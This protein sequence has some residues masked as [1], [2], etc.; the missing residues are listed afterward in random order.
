MA[1]LIVAVWTKGIAVAGV[2]VE[3]VVVVVVVVVVGVVVVVVVVVG[4]VVVGVVSF[5]VKLSELPI[6]ASAN[7]WGRTNCTGVVD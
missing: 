6:S 4:V 7:S 3:V 5:L 1:G 2:V